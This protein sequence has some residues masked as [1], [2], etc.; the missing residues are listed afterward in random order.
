MS[1]DAKSGATSGL[2]FVSESV[3]E[4]RRQRRQEE[5]EKNRTE[6]MPLEAPEEPYDSRTL[7]ERLK[8]QKDIKDEEFEE[9]RKLKNMIK[10]LDSDEVSFL[11]MVDNRK[12]QLESQRLREE[13]QTIEEYKRA[14]N[15]LNHEEQEKRLNDMKR[16]IFAKNFVQNETNSNKSVKK[17]SQSALLATVVR[18]R[19][20][21]DSQSEDKTPPKKLKTDATTDAD[22]KDSDGKGSET[23][24]KCQTMQVLSALESFR[25][26]GTMP[27]VIAVIPTTLP[28]AK[29]RELTLI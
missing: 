29:S 11:E 14:V 27:T 12:L 18:R 25:D 22:Q 7:Y 6:D 26:S 21:S 10:G 16:N 23:S 9:S 5:Y 3:L 2:S 20:H 8:E 13:S 19:T 15:D 4:E 1:L 17:S 28:T 24:R